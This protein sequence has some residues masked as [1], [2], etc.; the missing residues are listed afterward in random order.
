MG[1]REQAAADARAIVGDTATGFGWP[2]TVRNPDGVE[3]E[4][5]GLTNDIHQ[6]IDPDTGMPVSGRVASVVLSLA[7][8]GSIEDLGIPVGISDGARKPWIVMWT[9]LQGVDQTFKVRETR[10]DRSAGLIVCLLE[11]YKP[12]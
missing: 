6:T 5:S 3:A 7:D 10:P 12:E 8:L 9:D 2:V 1:L 11:K 4:L